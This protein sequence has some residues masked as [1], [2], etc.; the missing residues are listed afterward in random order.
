MERKDRELLEAV[1]TIIIDANKGGIK[2][3]IQD[4]EDEY[5]EKTKINE[6]EE[7]NQIMPDDETESINIIQ[8]NE[9]LKYFNELGAFSPDGKEYYITVNKNNRL[10]IIWSQ[11]LA[12]EKFGTLVT[13]SLGGYTWYK[14]SRLNRVTSWENRPTMDPP[15]ESIFIKDTENNKTWSVGLNPK[16]D[17]KEYNIIY[18]FGYAKYLHKSDGIEQ[19]LEV[20]VPKEDSIKIQTLKLKNVTP[21]K[22]KLKIVYYAKLVLGEDELKSNGYINLKYDENNNIICAKNI[23]NSEFPNDIIYISNSEKMR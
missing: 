9:N 6:I 5:S 17:D 23:Y 7:K 20:F 18:G 8:N 21:A 22:K 14:N 4:V 3:N 2:N 15:S 1:S 13:E 10:P 16:P 11:I 12:N 19:E